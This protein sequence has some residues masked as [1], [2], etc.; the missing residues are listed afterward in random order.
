MPKPTLT[1]AQAKRLHKELKT[2]VAID[3]QDRPRLLSSSVILWD[4][5]KSTNPAQ[6]RKIGWW[7]GR[8]HEVVWMT[9]IW[10]RVYFQGSIRNAL[11]WLES[12]Q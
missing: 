1:E 12:I 11:A 3:G 5:S 2:Y 8:K 10:G 6:R 9:R 7:L 4:N